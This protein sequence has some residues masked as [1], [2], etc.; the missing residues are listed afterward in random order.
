MPLARPSSDL[1]R[2]LDIRYA[3]A[4]GIDLCLD[5]LG[6]RHYP[7][8]RFRPS[9]GSMAAQAGDPATGR[10]WGRHE[11]ALAR[12]FLG[13]LARVARQRFGEPDADIQAAAGPR[14]AG[15]VT[16]VG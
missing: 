6:P 10:T 11:A 15:N 5:V 7:P 2:L 3:S 8:R 13:L 14:E 16:V 12:V 9:C 1:T 4:D